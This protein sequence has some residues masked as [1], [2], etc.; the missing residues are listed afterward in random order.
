MKPNKWKPKERPLSSVLG[1]QPSSNN[2]V[3][4][5]CSKGQSCMAKEPIFRSCF[6]QSGSDHFRMGK[7][8]F[9]FLF[10]FFVFSFVFQT[11]WLT[12][13]A[14]RSKAPCR[15]TSSPSPRRAAPAAARRPS[16]GPRSP[17]RPRAFSTPT[18]VR[19]FLARKMR[20]A[21]IFFWILNHKMAC[22]KN[23]THMEETQFC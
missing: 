13:V 17:A 20:G 19:V 10:R 16:A 2:Q 8:P 15:P 12:H 11:H 23:S 14:L 21:P 6:S 9:I 3:P 5:T 7:E 1:P 18:G 22:S 4:I